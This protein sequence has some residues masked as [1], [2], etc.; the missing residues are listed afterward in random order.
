MYRLGFVL[1]STFLIVMLVARGLVGDGLLAELRSPSRWFHLGATAAAGGLWWAAQ[2][3]KHAFLTL[4]LFDA[5]GVLALVVLLNFNAGLFDIRTV[6]VFNLVLTTGIALILRAV[7]VPSTPRRTLLIG[8]AASAVTNAIFFLS[9]LHP[10]WPVA[11][12]GLVDW[13][14][15]YQLVSLELWLA[16]LVATATVASRVIY[17]LRHEVRVARR[18]GQYVLGQKLGEGAM[19]IVYRATHAM[20]RRETAIKLLPPERV[21][22]AALRHFE[23]EV[24]QTARLRHPNTV[25]IFD[26]GRTPEGIFYYAMEYLEGYTVGELV[27]REGPLPPGRAIH[28]LAQVCASLEEAHLVGLVHR[29]IK[30]ANV[31]VVGNP[32]AYDHVKVLDFGLVKIRTPDATG[33]SFD[34]LDKVVGTP[35][36]LAP[37]A[38][39]HP[40][41]VDG[42]S[43][44][45]AVAAVGYFML[46][47]RDVFDGETLVEICA[48][49]LYETPSPIPSAPTDLEALLLRGL[50]K[51]PSE[52]PQTAAHFRQALLACAVPPWSE[53]DARSWWLAHGRGSSAP[54]PPVHDPEA[55]GPTITA[56]RI[57]SAPDARNEAV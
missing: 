2:R 49:H 50:S 7:I 5:G 52:R 55:D 27:R 9:A 45:Y 21:G 43:D 15:A 51:A 23:R 56:V 38:I 8:I 12:F 25:A 29:D 47:G 44:L 19:G 39:T 31:M 36:Y 41:Q 54:P 20:L 53:E 1:S 42:R 18:L 3:K 11:Q 16:V 32:A 24:V 35:L 26:Y 46:T 30:P 57:D 13:P 37:E 4:E 28:L 22:P 34:N 14:L 40:D 10:G 33:S 17:H 48:A 6:A